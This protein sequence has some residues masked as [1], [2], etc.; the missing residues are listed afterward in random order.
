MLEKSLLK[1][2]SVN[3]DEIHTQLVFQS[4]LPTIFDHYA[5]LAKAAK[6]DVI[7]TGDKDLLVLH[8][9]DSTQIITPADFLKL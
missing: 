6:A 1:P 3:F 9:F 4:F 2:I 5:S 7:I 8:P